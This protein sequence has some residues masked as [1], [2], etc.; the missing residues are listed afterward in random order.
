MEVLHTGHW[1]GQSISYINRD[2]LFTIEKYFKVIEDGHDVSIISDPNVQ[3]CFFFYDKNSNHSLLITAIKL[4]QNL[5]KQLIIIYKGNIE[6][7]ILNLDV[8]FDHYRLSS[9][10][11]SHWC[12]QLSKNVYFRFTDH[13]SIL[14]IYKMELDLTEH[15]ISKDIVEILKYI[16][17]NIAK[18]IREEDIADY[19][20][21]SV[22][23][24]SK[25]FHKSVGISFRD[26]LTTKRIELAKKLLQDD[27]KNKI[28][29][30]AYQCGYND[31]SYF[32]RIFKKKTGI[33]PGVFRQFH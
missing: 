11:I 25:L 22:S 3:F 23:Y 16:D 18:T 20:H 29:V 5:H 33:S 17:A 2:T 7:D 21:Y 26:Y 27:K 28:A 9:F 14:D 15:K 10:D 6:E 4:C 32:S 8:V 19:C 13:Q 12:E 31:V 30:I 24:F 1:I